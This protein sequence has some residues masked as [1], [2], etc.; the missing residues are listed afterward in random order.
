MNKLIAES[1]RSPA[2]AAAVATEGHAGSFGDFAVSAATERARLNAAMNVTPITGSAR[3]ASVSQSS[4]GTQMREGVDMS[5]SNSA[6]N[7]TPSVDTESEQTMV[8]NGMPGSGS[9]SPAFVGN[10]SVAIPA[11]IQDRSANMQAVNGDSM[12]TSAASVP[13][14]GAGWSDLEEVQAHP[15]TERELMTR[16]DG[17]IQQAEGADQPLGMQV[18]RFWKK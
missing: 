17:D 6:N 9:T 1:D 18:R 10:G 4:N 15:T 11:L 8:T 12:A 7:D 16:I 14:Q 13:Q 2:R 5:P 3:A